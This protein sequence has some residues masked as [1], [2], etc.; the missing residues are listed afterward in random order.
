MSRP[1]TDIALESAFWNTYKTL[2]A[3]RVLPYQWRA[4]NDEV[5]EIPP[6][7]AITNLRI[8]AGEAE[9]QYRGLVFQDSD[10]AKWIEAVA[11]SLR[12]RPDAEL[13]ARVDEVVALLGRVQQPDGY[14]N[15]FYIATEPPENRWN[16]LR[17]CHELYCAGH[18]IEAAVTYADVT[19][20]RD[21]LDIAI[22][23][24]D[25]IE[26]TFGRGEGQLRGYP[27]H[28]EIELALV[29]LFE[30]TSDRRYLDLAHYFLTERG[31]APHYYDLEAEARS[32][33]DAAPQPCEV[34]NPA[35]V[36]GTHLNYGLGYAFQQAHEPFLEQTQAVGHAV[37]AVYLYAAAVD[38]AERTGDERL[39]ATADRL[40]RDVV[41][42]KLYITGGV[43]SQVPGE[44]FTTPYD[45]P[46][47]TMYC[48]TCAS[49]GLVFWAWRMGR[50]VADAEFG[51][52]IERALYN[53]TISGLG[54]DGESFFYINPLQYSAPMD[55]RQL[56]WD[57]SR[58]SNRRQRWFSCPCC[59]MNLARLI[60]SIEQYVFIAEPTGLRV[61]QYI[62]TTARLHHDGT[63]VDVRLDSG[64]PWNGDV[65]VTI[66]TEQ[67]V[68]LTLRLRMPSWAAGAVLAVDDVVLPATTDGEGYLVVH[69]TWH[70][71][72][73]VV[74][75][76]AMPVRAVR[77]HTAVG[78]NAGKVALTRGPI[79]YCVEEA[80]NGPVLAGLVLD[81]S[82]PVDLDPRPDLL[83]GITSLRAR[84]FRDEPDDDEAPLYTAV[85]PRRAP[86]EL[87]A[88]PYY[89]WANREQG[90]MRLWLRSLSN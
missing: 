70:G 22:R 75:E 25:L 62:G 72:A 2:V 15:S 33:L 67:P 19:G 17:D 43:G 3:E 28:P 7:R 45:L 76:L 52:V 39:R 64:M 48:E 27:G 18:L 69:R 66:E 14:L 60:A 36:D 63:D 88:V 24:A 44:S 82:A 81:P 65:R 5:P 21:L 8:A 40:W 89:S 4:L 12:E 80:D 23:Y 10:I 29:R 16:N 30:A 38:V 35:H 73:S 51:D 74:V 1:L 54:L 78:E 13:E 87:T 47:E 79:V 71:R 58:P 90:E 11:H 46:N 53:G 55:E 9:G 59:P 57:I 49:V 77:A 31:T 37:R 86:V 26:Q 50:T 85:A 56:G 41:D 32:R 20:K 6:S 34:L 83:G 61:E 84:G 42:S 68:E